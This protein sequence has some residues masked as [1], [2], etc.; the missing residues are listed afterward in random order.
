MLSDQEIFIKLEITIDEISGKLKIIT[1]FDLNAPN[2]LIDNEGLAWFPTQKEKEIFSETYEIFSNS[3]SIN[4]SANESSNNLNNN[5]EK[6]SNL[7]TQNPSADEKMI[8]DKVLIQKKKI[9]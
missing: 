6:G 1:H 9:N 2:I 7:I 5:Y 4:S 8:I 3:N